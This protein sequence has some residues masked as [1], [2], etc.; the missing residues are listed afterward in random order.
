[1]G[2]GKEGQSAYARTWPTRRCEK[3]IERRGPGLVSSRSEGAH[4]SGR[5]PIARSIG[6]YVRRVRGTDDG[7]GSRETHPRGSCQSSSKSS[8]PGPSLTTV[9]TPP[10]APSQVT[11]RSDVPNEPSVHVDVSNRCRKRRNLHLRHEGRSDH[12]CEQRKGARRLAHS[13]KAPEGDHGG[14]TQG[15]GRGRGRLRRGASCGRL[16]AEA[17]PTRC[18]F[19]PESARAHSPLIPIPPPK[20]LGENLASVRA[21]ILTTRPLPPALRRARAPTGPVAGGPAREEAST[22]GTRR[23]QG[24]RRRRRR[25]CRVKHP[26][27]REAGPRPPRTRRRGG[28]RSDAARLFV[29]RRRR[30]SRPPPPLSPPPRTSRRRPRNW[31]NRC[32]AVLARRS[33]T[34]IEPRA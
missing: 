12:F 19:E 16:R 4:L 27:R 9:A 13:P 6:F 29:K 8:R 28:R 18:L 22:R 32:S 2:E 14:Q 15:R 30:R 31:R 25:R 1:M 5:P 11:R 17:V 23:G 7:S 24:R 20:N 3:T 26:R 34:R 10:V 33:Q 21:R